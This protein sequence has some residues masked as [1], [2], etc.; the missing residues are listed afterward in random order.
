MT[1][2]CILHVLPGYVEVGVINLVANAV[3]SRCRRRNTGGPCSE[4]GVED[5]V[6][7]ERKESYQPFR[8][9]LWEGRRVPSQS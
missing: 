1:L 7:G 9:D 6:P 2:D 5:R 4:K 8:K 3:S